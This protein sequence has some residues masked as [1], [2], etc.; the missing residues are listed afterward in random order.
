MLE[1]NA[2]SLKDLGNITPI[3]LKLNFH[4]DSGKARAEF[5]LNE[6][7]QGPYGY[8]HEGILAFAID[9]GMG[10]AAR[11]IGGFNSVTAT[12]D[13]RYYNPAGINEPLAVIAEITKN[14]RHLLEVNARIERQDGAL[15]A[16]GTCLQYVMGVNKG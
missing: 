10:W 12:L 11:H 4:S 5:T 14:N 1:R 3:G 7:Y 15:I 2:K 9:A 13:I 6:N 8:V 16:E